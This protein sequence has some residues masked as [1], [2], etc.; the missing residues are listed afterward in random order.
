[1]NSYMVTINAEHAQTVYTSIN[2]YTYTNE[3]IIFRF[4]KTI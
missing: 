3:R 1:M 4:Y 2:N